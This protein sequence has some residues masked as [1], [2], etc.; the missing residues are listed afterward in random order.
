MLHVRVGGKAS[1]FYANLRRNLK[2][3]PGAGTE[4]EKEM[5]NWYQVLNRWL[6]CYIPLS[7]G[8]MLDFVHWHVYCVDRGSRGLGFCPGSFVHSVSAV[9]NSMSNFGEFRDLLVMKKYLSEPQI[10]H[11]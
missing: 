11:C 2:S 7:S 9:C 6:L 4:S 3:F 10:N 1:Q 5:R 8:C